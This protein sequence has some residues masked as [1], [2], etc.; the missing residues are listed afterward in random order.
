MV[1]AVLDLDE[2]A[3][4]AVHALDQVAGGL[5]HRHDVVDADRRLAVRAEAAIGGGR[6]LLAIAEHE[7]DLR[8]RGEAGRVDLRGAARDHDPRRRV[9]APRLADRLP[10]LAHRLA[11]DG[12]G[13]DEDRVAQPAASARARITSD[14]SAFS[15][16]PK[17]RVLTC[18]AGHHAAP[19]SAD[20]PATAS[21]VDG[22]LELGLDRAGHDDVVVVAPCDA[23]AARREASR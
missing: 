1:A 20:R 2:G 9:L 22:A 19:F 17:V 14:S 5:P 10:G 11:G 15:R 12:A 21:R 3:G 18:V 16:Q 4:T 13:V 6:Q 7:V 23:A 8:H